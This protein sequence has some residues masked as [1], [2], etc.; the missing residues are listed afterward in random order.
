V[1]LGSGCFIFKHYIFDYLISVIKL[2]TRGYQLMVL[3]LR[4]ESKNA[5]VQDHP[6]EE[7]VIYIKISKMQHSKDYLEREIEKL[8]LMLIGLIEKV[9]GLSSNTASDEL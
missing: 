5:Y 7:A 9:T 3:L 1:C 2:A 4:T 8:S 6:S